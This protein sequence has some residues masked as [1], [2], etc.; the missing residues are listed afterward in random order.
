METPNNKPKI[1]KCNAPKK[2]FLLSKPMGYTYEFHHFGEEYP[3]VIHPK[4][5]AK[6]LNFNLETN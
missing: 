6:S 4:P 3:E 5:N 1:P 2:K